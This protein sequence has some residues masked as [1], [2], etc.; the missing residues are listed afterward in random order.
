MLVGAKPGYTLPIPSLKF[1]FHLECDMESFHHIGEGGHGDRS[2]V[3]FKGGRFEGP[4]VRGTILPGGGDWETI[5]NHNGDQQTAYLDTR[6]NLLTHDDVCIFLKTT[7]TR[8]G[9]KSVLEELGE[10]DKHGPEEFKMRLN[11]TFECG[12]ER[13]SWLNRA[14]AIASS[15][16]NGTRVIYDAYEVL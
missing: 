1:L 16:R 11:L 6:Y 7:G 10:E 4:D 12:D 15:G 14:V 9:K 5:Q 3:I 8:T 2:T 13:Y